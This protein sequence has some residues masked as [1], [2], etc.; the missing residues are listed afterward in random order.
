VIAAIA[1]LAIAVAVVGKLTARQRAWLIGSP[2]VNPEVTELLYQGA[3]AQSRQSYQGWR[4]AITYFERAIAIQPDLAQAYSAISICYLQFS[5]VGPLAPAEFMPQAE[6]AA[7]K[8][9]DLDPRFAE[10][11]V[12]RAM[13]LYRYYWNWSEA[14]SEFK[15]AL[16]LNPE[17]SEGHRTYAEFLAAAGRPEEG[18]LQS[19]RARELDPRPVQTLLQSAAAFRAAGQY[20]EAVRRLREALGKSPESSRAHFQLGITDTYRGE[21]ND[22]VTELETAVR[23]AQGHVCSPTWD[24][25]MP[26]LD[27]QKMRSGCSVA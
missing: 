16:D 9:I 1:F 2:P 20:D 5:F 13:V 3:L 14:E 4:D 10:P 11:H 19:Q 24:M 8:A 18:L 12:A 17:Y 25:P 23:L 6:Q 15:Q 21:L 26:W 27:G 7:G 22:A